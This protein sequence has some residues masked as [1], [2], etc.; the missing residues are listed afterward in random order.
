MVSPCQN[1]SA[2]VYFLLVL[3]L[4]NGQELMFERQQRVCCFAPV[5][6]IVGVLFATYWYI[7]SDPSKFEAIGLG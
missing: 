7:F 2:G 5:C 1:S 3:V 6:R 4:S